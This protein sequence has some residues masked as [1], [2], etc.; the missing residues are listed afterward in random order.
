[1]KKRL[2]NKVAV[3]T[4][5]SKGIGA[6]IAKKIAE[7]GAS[8][9]VNFTRSNRDAD[10]V[11]NQIQSQGG[12]A[13]AVQ[14]DISEQAGCDRLFDKC[15]EQYG[16][17]DILVNNAGIY[18]PASLGQINADHFHKQF[19]LNVLGLILATQTALKLMADKSV[20]VNV[21]SVVSTLSP[22][23]MSV[24]NAT[25]A[26]VDSLTRTFAKELAD[27]DIRVNSVNPGLIATEGTKEA[28]IVLDG[29]LEIPNLGKIG[30][31]EDIADGVVF[32]ASDE[33]RWMSGQSI[34]MNGSP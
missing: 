2:E 34:V 33:S 4:G 6:A 11:V 21:S 22:P 26:A 15:H 24:Y 9:I 32:L 5:S 28:G 29:Q 19:N 8:V 1:M 20:I 7:E 27:R 16:R 30:L 3:V 13:T 10:H 23:H 14:A 17:L 18:L 31:P 12:S 25:K